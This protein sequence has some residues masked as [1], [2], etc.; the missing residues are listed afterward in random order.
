MQNFSVLALMFVPKMWKVFQKKDD[1][2]TLR[3]PRMRGST[4][5]SFAFEAS[6]NRMMPSNEYDSNDSLPVSTKRQSSASVGSDDIGAP[7]RTN[8]V[9]EEV[10]AT[11]RETALS[12]TS[13]QD[14]TPLH[15]GDRESKS[16]SPSAVVPDARKTAEIVMK[17]EPET[18]VES[19]TESTAVLA[20]FKDPGGSLAPP[21]SDGA[22]DSGVSTVLAAE[23]D[24]AE[25]DA[26]SCVLDLANLLAPLPDH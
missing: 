2:P 19:C 14:V 13:E 5:V 26:A 11:S 7:F 10:L 22:G 23:G 20:A 12:T 8:L 4:R 24:N 18:V 9:V 6:N 17:E 15:D 25:I 1:L 3:P 21:K 16:L